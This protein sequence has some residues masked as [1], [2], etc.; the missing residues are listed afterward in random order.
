M[1]YDLQTNLHGR[2]NRAAVENRSHP[3]RDLFHGPPL[4]RIKVHLIELVHRGGR[5]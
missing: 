1:P 4:T 2:K 3:Q 5:F